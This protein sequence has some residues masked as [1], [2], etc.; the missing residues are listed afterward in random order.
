MRYTVLKLFIFS[1]F[2]SFG[3]LYN[4]SLAQNNIKN[5]KAVRIE[6]PPKIDGIIDEAVWQKAN[7]AGDFSQYEPYND[8]PASLNTEVKILY[9]D[10][11]IYIAAIM[12]DSAPD[13]ILTE[14]GLRDSGD[15]LNADRFWVDINPFNDGVNGFRFQVS[16]SGIQTDMNMSGYTGNG[17]D[18]NWDAVWKSE[19]KI[20][21]NGWI[22]EMEIPYSALRFPKQNVHQWGINFWREIRRTR[23]SS[24]WN[25]VNRRIGNAIAS[26]GVLNGIEDITPPLRLALYP[27]LSNY[28]E[29]NHQHNGWK[30]TINGGI[31]LKLGISESFTMDMTLIPDFGQVQSDALVLNLSPYEV[32]YD[33]KRQFFTEGTE[34]FGKANLFYSRRIG[35]RPKGY[36][37]AYSE[38]QENEYITE[39]PIETRLINATKISG[40]TK[41]GLGIGIFN[42]MTA[43]SHAIITDTI[44]EVDRTIVTQPFTNYNLLVVDQSLKNNSYISLVNTNVS[45]SIDGYTANVTGTDFRILDKTNMYRISGNAALSQQYFNN[46][47]DNLGYKYSL[48]AGKIGGT[49]QYGYYRNVANNTYEQNDMGF[50]RHNNY[51]SNGVSLSY[52]IF[53]PFWRFWNVTNVL[54]FDNSYLYEPNAYAGTTLGYQLRMLFDTRFFINFSAHYAPL[55]QRDFF[56]PRVPGRFYEIGEAMNLYLFVS[57]DYRKRVYFDGGINYYKIFTSHNEEHITFDAKPTFRASDKLNLSY[58]FYYLEKINNIGYVR[59]FSDNT[60][61]FGKRHSPTLT[62]SI[63]ANYI[64]SKDISLRFNLRHYWSKVNYNDEYFLLN[65]DGSLNSIDIA[66]EFRANDINYNAFTIDM[67]LVWYF[68]PGSQL[69]LVWKNAIYSNSDYLPLSYFDNLNHLMQ[70][71]QINSFSIKVLYYLDYQNIKRLFSAK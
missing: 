6:N 40:R 45:G 36:F 2:I 24:S 52:N 68:A 49:W 48:N 61:I 65:F 71:P 46:N 8:R 25:F 42:A 17:G 37:I 56:E 31:D 58:R 41:S 67:M 30:N 47:D 7:I 51:I 55:T 1:V 59:H 20:I 39:N 53:D 12:Y 21:E 16:A 27:Y 64:F 26:L 60:I 18:K 62:N 32:K 15:Q 23:E 43:S 28:V 57:S 70:E 11:S 29:N 34:L 63:T 14:L 9:D 22:V 54:S 66:D 10:K 5:I 69:S 44:N 35:S 13:S 38:L 33:E 19:V 50:L 4:T 3:L